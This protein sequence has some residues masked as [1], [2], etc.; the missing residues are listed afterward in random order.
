[1]KKELNI[2]LTASISRLNIITNRL[3]NTN[4]VGS[5]RSVFRGRGLEF[6]DYRPYTPNDDASMI[7]WKASVKSQ[8]L[9]V[10]EFIEERNLSVFFLI[11][12]SS[13]MIY[14]SIDKLKIEY[15][16]ELI[17]T[18]S[19]AVMHAGDSV[20]FALF[21]DKVIRYNLPS[22]GAKSHFTLI[23]TLVDTTYYGGNYDLSEAL[24][25]TLTSLKED[26]IVIIVSDFIGLKNEWENK[27]KMLA[28]KFDVIGIMIRDPRDKTL[29]D[30]NG[31]VILGDMYSD[32]QI[33]A[34]VDS[35]RS[36]YSEY[37]ESKEKEI[38]KIFSDAGGDFVSLITDRPFVAP[39]T[40]LFLR[41]AKKHSS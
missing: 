3:V 15:A 20:G 4:F 2:D 32:R 31:K 10:K 14:A 6:A 21:N 1:M 29:P 7:D 22:L 25:F 24:K 27:L 16:A 9:F 36:Q 11:D 37:V 34:D 17:A 19:F 8:E 35:I 39:I 13:T 5:Y 40:D 18:L 38:S 33:I 28:K 41:R 30:Y 12:V 23:K 26:S